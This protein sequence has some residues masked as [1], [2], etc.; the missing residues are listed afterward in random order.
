MQFG[1]LGGVK[2]GAGK[3]TKNDDSDKY[4]YSG[5]GIRFDSRGTFSHPSGGFGKN[6]IIFGADMSSS[7]HVNNK[8]KNILVL[9]EGFTEGLDNNTLYAETMYSTNF[10]VC[11]V[12]FKFAL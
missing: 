3:L 11:K 12:L 5:Y 10:T 2:F 6:V 8:T 7:I 9:G 1:A 4:K